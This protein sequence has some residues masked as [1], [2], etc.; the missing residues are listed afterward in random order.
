LLAIEGDLIGADM[1]PTNETKPRDPRQIIGAWKKLS[2]KWKIAVI[3]LLVL[4][5]GGI[6]STCNSILGNNTN[7]TESTR[8]NQAEESGGKTDNPGV[9]TDTSGTKTLASKNDPVPTGVLK[10]HYIDVGQGDSTFVELPNGQSMLIDAGTASVGPTVVSYINKL[11][12]TK[13]DYLIATHPEEDHIGGISLV[14]ESS[15]VGEV[16]APKATQTTGSYEN[17]LNA[18]QAKGLSIRTAEEG[19][20][21][22]SSTDLEVDILAPARNASYSDLNDWSVIVAVS[23][24]D[25]VFL[26]TGDASSSAILSAFSKHV[27]VLK[28]GHHGSNTSTDSTLVSTLTPNYAIISCGSGNSYGH[29]ANDVLQALST[30]NVYRTDKQ[31]T[32][33]IESDGKKITPHAQP[34]KYETP[35]VESSG[36]S[37]PSGSSSASNTSDSSGSSNSSST[38]N[39]ESTPN[40]MTVYITNTGTKYHLGSCKYLKKSKI[41]TTLSSAKSQGYEPCETCKPPS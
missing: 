20:Q 25:N 8:I 34:V 31:G 29:P 1:E 6:A 2:K 7:S 33:I 24:G 9:I 40:D 23:F 3:I 37:G 14:I 35:K 26:F 12:Y 36:A 39:A 41:A 16:W 15:D 17:F 32:I 38:S 10:A 22:L 13:I 27:D 21:I 19:K 5:L 11:G 28:V 30:T 18:V 4:V